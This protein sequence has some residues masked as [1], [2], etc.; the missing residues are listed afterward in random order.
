MFI[1]DGI[2]YDTLKTRWD[3]L[4]LPMIKQIVDVLTFGSRKYSDNNWK[5]IPDAKTRYLAAMMRHVEQW[6]SGERHDQES[7]Y[8]HLAHAGCCLLFILW[9]DE[10]EVACAKPTPTQSV[11]D[12]PVVN[13][14]SIIGT[15]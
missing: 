8:H 7:G 9:F 3:L 12:A 6:Q 10:N 4:P 14:S 2:K 11:V 5:M 13:N 1:E 15:Y